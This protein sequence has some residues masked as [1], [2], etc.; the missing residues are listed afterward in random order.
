MR[1]RIDFVNA[2]QHYFGQKNFLRRG[3]LTLGRIYGC[4]K[5]S[6]TGGIS[7]SFRLDPLCG[8]PIF[9]AE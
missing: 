5:E 3:L 1:V 8:G 2:N 6:G 4:L 7:L 9:S